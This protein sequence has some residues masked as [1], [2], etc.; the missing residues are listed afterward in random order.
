M[1]DIEEQKAKLNQLW[2]EFVIKTANVILGSRVTWPIGTEK[3]ESSKWFGLKLP[4]KITIRKQIDALPNNSSFCIELFLSGH[5]NSEDVLLERWQIKS[6]PSNS[7]ERIGTELGAGYK[8]AIIMI[9]SLCSYLLLLPTHNAVKEIA[10]NPKSPSK[11]SYKILNTNSGQRFDSAES[12]FSFGPIETGMG[13][14]GLDVTYLTTIPKK[15][16]FA[17]IRPYDIISDFYSPKDSP[18]FPSTFP[19]S[20][21]SS[22]KPPIAPTTRSR[23]MSL[24]N[25][26]ERTRSSQDL[27]SQSYYESNGSQPVSIPRSTTSPRNIPS[28]TPPF[29]ATPQSFESPSGILSSSITPPFEDSYNVGRHPHSQNSDRLSFNALFETSMP[30]THD[31]SISQPDHDSEDDDNNSGE[32]DGSDSLPFAD[33]TETDGDD[34]DEIGFFLQQMRAAPPLDFKPTSMELYKSELVEYNDL[35]PEILGQ[36]NSDVNNVS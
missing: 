27:S 5:P 15:V 3:G 19:S 1:A 25:K 12:S 6:K 26:Q 34:E 31:D 11:I 16:T 18:D 8:K 21:D 23:A 20:N 9:R 14:I 35:V 4:E 13:R 29:A 36:G 28:S 33:P 7:N 17:P 10:K 30:S 22:G 32:I 24:P 2:K